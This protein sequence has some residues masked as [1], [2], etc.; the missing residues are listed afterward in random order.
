MLIA[1]S[2]LFAML[3]LIMPFVSGFG[4]VIKNPSLWKTWWGVIGI[5]VI[6][7][8]WLGYTYAKQKDIVFSKLLIPILI[9]FLWSL[10]S[11]IWSINQ[12]LA[13]FTVVTYFSYVLVFILSINLL[14][15]K[16][17][18]F[19]MI[20]ALALTSFIVSLTGLVEYY[21]PEYYSLIDSLYFQTGDLGTFFG[22]KNRS[23]QYVVMTLPFLIYLFINGKAKKNDVMSSISLFVIFL[24]LMNASAR[25]GYL[26]IIVELFLVALFIILDWHKHKKQA[27]FSNI[28]HAKFKAG[29]ITITIGMLL[30]SL[31]AFS[32]IDR[33]QDK[34]ER[35]VSI[36]EG[37]NNTRIPVWV[38]TLEII[39]DHSIIGAGA[40]QWKEYYPLYYNH[41]IFDK[42]SGEKV[43]FANAHNDYLQMLSDYG[44]IGFL[45]LAWIAYLFIRI[46]VKILINH[47]NK[48]RLLGLMLACSLSGFSVVALVSFPIG[49][50]LPGFL[51]MICLGM[52]SILDGSF[53]QG[54]NLI[55][56]L[57]KSILIVILT[58]VLISIFSLNYTF[59][60]F[61]GEYHF[62]E[63]IKNFRAGFVNQSIVDV[64]KSLTSE[65]APRFYSK[66]G[67]YFV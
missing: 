18:L 51:V 30:I 26:A 54:L 7:I 41:A 39:K 61:K 44:I 43:K 63:S 64:N 22:N 56:P 37:A 9:F 6:F 13:V 14:S 57:K 17:L 5:T 34:F 33:S 24:Y 46:I 15:K 3:V 29:L 19:W 48:S 25:Q 27:L 12:S 16:Q 52:L 60:S 65:E 2:R 40:G 49:W 11:I 32:P 4:S 8:I 66:I 31:F 47:N 20:L 23:V 62:R 35:F 58:A 59:N 67:S 21:F 36:S 38:N 45:L 42:H 10:A 55:N 1:L 50:Y 53:N 28:K